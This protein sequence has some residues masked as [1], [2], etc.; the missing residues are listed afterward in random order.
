[1][2]D[3]ILEYWW[4][5]AVYLVGCVL[6]YGS[7]AAQFPKRKPDLLVKGFLIYCSWIGFLAIIICRR[8]GEKFFKFF[9]ALLLFTLFAV[10]C[11]NQPYKYQC[12]S[13]DG[14]SHGSYFQY[15]KGTRINWG[16]GDPAWKIDSC[17]EFAIKE[18][19]LK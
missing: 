1:M 10:C 13:T 6:A 17:Y 14:T 11:K 12:L 19:A 9:P 5:I 18:N 2:M 7:Y 16:S 4:Q 8:K 3:F 15:P